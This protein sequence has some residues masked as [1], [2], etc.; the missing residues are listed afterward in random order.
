MTASL[1]VERARTS[2]VILF[3]SFCSGGAFVCASLWR[4]LP[5]R[6]APANVHTA[7][8]HSFRFGD[9]I[10]SVVTTFNRLDIIL[11]DKC[12]LNTSDSGPA[13]SMRLTAAKL[14]SEYNMLHRNKKFQCSSGTESPTAACKRP[15]VLGS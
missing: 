15:Y 14:F 13:G 3:S 6:L 9:I 11:H 2:A 8:F 10:L 4:G 7:R 5:T 12:L 1:S